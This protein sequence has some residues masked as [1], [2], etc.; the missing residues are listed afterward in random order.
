[1]RPDSGSDYFA[2]LPLLAVLAVLNP[3]AMEAIALAV[4]IIAALRRP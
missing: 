1:M 3:T 2:L 4:G